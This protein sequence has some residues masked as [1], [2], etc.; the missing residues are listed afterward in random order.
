MT[1]VYLASS[2]KNYRLNHVIYRILESK[3]TSCFLPQRDALEESLKNAG[4]N[5][6]EV[7][8]KIRNANVNGIESADV[9]LV[10]AK[11]IGADSTWECGFAAGL[12]K[13]V[14]LIR[15]PKDPVEDVYML[16]NSVNHII[17][18]RRYYTKELER[19]I[20]SFDFDAIGRGK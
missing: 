20:N 8:S 16:F 9:V 13:L 4:K 1:K 12:G 14:I 11:N 17:E 18:V 5:N 2:L 10:I 19:A 6:H 15:T 3:G 7:A